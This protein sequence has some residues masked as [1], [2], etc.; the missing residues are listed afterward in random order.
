MN[1]RSR[2]TIVAARDALVG[3]TPQA[4]GEEAGLGDVVGLG[5]G[6]DRRLEVQVLPAFA[7]R[8]QQ[9]DRRALAR[10]RL[11]GRLGADPQRLV[12][13]AD[14][15]LSQQVDRADHRGRRAEVAGQLDHLPGGVGL[16]LPP[17]LAEGVEVGVAEAVDR[18][19]RVA[20]DHQL[21]RRAAEPVDEPDLKAVRVLE[22]V[23]HHLPEARSVGA[24]DLLPLEQ[25]GGE[26]LQVLEV[27]PA[28]ALLD[29]GEALAEELA[30][31]GATW[32]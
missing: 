7:R 27:D 26:Q 28:A 17:L 18:L 21:R 31:G 22:L 23:D 32:S 29:R 5:A 8:Q 1:A 12:L 3:E 19:Q 4:L 2:T 10:G 30:A 14:Q 6:V 13:V 24:A 11:L 15:A 20:D 16:D 25:A 9:L